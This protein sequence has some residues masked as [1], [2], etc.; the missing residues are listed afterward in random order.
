[1]RKRAAEKRESSQERYESVPTKI[2]TKSARVL[3]AE[4]WRRLAKQSRFQLKEKTKK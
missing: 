2:V 1:M 3:T 4:G